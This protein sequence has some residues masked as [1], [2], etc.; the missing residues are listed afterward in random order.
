MNKTWIFAAM[1]LALGTSCSK[2]KGIDIDDSPRQEILLGTGSTINVSPASRGYGAVGGADEATNKWN[3]ETLYVYGITDNAANKA[4]INGV[5]AV[6]PKGAV[7]GNLTWAEN[8]PVKH[9]YYEGNDKYNFYAVHVDGA[10]GA[11][12]DLSV[13]APAD[14]AT[15]GHSVNVTI[16]GT[17]DLM[18]AM[19]NKDNDILDEEGT[20][21]LEGVENTTNLYSAW[22]ARRGV[23]PNLVFKHLLSRLNF[24][25]YCGDKPVPADGNELKITSITIKNTI[26]KGSIV[27]IPAYSEPATEPEAKNQVF[28]AAEEPN[29]GDF[30]IMKKKA[31]G[32]TELK[33]FEEFP[34][35]GSEQEVGEDVLVV[36]V[37]SYD[38]EVTTVQNINGEPKTKTLNTTLTADMIK[39]GEES[40]NLEKFVEGEMYDVTLK[41][42]AN[43][44]IQIE[45]TLTAWVD[46][47]D[48][49]LDEE[50]IEY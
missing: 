33:P 49:T 44:E 32:E 1:A 20:D 16:D 6:A 5:K 27:V 17:Q 46:G 11:D 18:V 8:E 40:A 47:G 3:G 34:L 45:C 14:L 9:F 43:Q 2:E 42:Y 41:L 19:P 25:A 7:T 35:T 21:N 29:T 30:V 36:P 50:T 24:K 15:T 13:K 39:K 37:G 28:D 22:S 38:I 10:A 31:E 26:N 12:A 23:V 48:A 4:P